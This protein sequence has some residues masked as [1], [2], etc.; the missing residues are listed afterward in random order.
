MIIKKS[1]LIILWRHLTKR[2]QKQ[3][4]LLLI[5]MVFASLAEIISI[6]AVLPFLGVLTAPEQV[7]QHSLMQLVIQILALTEPKQ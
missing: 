5:L 3:F 4:S 6:G 7:Y 2:R 1:S